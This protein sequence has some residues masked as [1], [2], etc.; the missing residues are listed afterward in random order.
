MTISVG[1]RLPEATLFE[2]TDQGPVRVAPAEFFRGK[3]GGACGLAGP[4]R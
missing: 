3:G 4:G 1:D 2:I